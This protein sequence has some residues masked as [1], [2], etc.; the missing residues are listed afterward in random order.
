MYI[1]IV[2]L[3]TPEVAFLPSLESMSVA[4]EVISTEL[5][6]VTPKTSLTRCSRVSANLEGRRLVYIANGVWFL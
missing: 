3:C 2:T 1:Y 4:R 5:N 6:A